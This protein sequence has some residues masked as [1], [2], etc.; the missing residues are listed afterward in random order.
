MKVSKPE[1]LEPVFI[2]GV[3]RSGTSLV[4]S[5]LAANPKL[6]FPPETSFIRRFLAKGRIT[7]AY[8]RGGLNEVHR[9]LEADEYLKRL[10]VSVDAILQRCLERQEEV[11]DYVFYAAMMECFSAKKER[12][13]WGDKDPRCIECLPLLFRHWPDAFVVHV[14]RDPRDV[15]AS[16]KRAKWSRRRSTLSHI[17]TNQAQMLLARRYGQR[18][19]GERYVTV[20]YENLLASPTSVLMSLCEDIDVPFDQR[21]LSFSNAAQELVTEGE[22]SW[23]EETL[24]PLLTQN[25]GKWRHQLSNGEAAL[26]ELVCT[27][28]FDHGCYSRGCSLDALSR[29]Q[30]ILTRW[31]AYA[32]KAV[33]HMYAS[34]R[35]L[36]GGRASMFPR[37]A[38]VQKDAPRQNNICR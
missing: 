13:R 8:R 3:G 23:K 31:I 17:A 12:P 22:R 6:A 20:L 34:G 33:A 19:F 37:R 18:L 14:I 4:H 1:S 26:V 15:L 29:T 35:M 2:V 21:M 10:P 24:G 7:K 5:M 38:L 25:V 11:C 36:F 30:R 9:I 32:L 28:A 16:R 27:E